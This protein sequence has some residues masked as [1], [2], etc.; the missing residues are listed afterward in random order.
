MT[1][2]GS[3]GTIS[4]TALRPRT[5]RVSPVVVGCHEGF[6]M[7]AYPVANRVGESPCWHHGQERLYWIDVRG[8][9]LLRLD[10]ATG[11][12]ER[13][14]LPDVVGSIAL[15]QSGEVWLALR[16][17]VHALDTDSGLLRLVA[18]VEDDRP[19]NR[20]NDGKVSPSGRWFVFG[21]MDDRPRKEPTGA[22]YCMSLQGELRTLWRGLVVANGIAFS[23]DGSTLYFSDSARGLVFKADWNE[24]RGCIGEP[25]IW[26]VLDEAAGRPDG[27]TVDTV[28]HYWSAGVSAGCLNVLDRSGALHRKLPVPCRAPTMPAFGGARSDVLFVTSLVRPDW[29]SAGV[30]DGA[31][32][33]LRGCGHGVPAALLGTH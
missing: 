7:L 31:L 28:G 5:D 27:A 18:S 15:C 8:Q 17:G 29:A 19:D 12:V 6:D 33:M 9:Q 30:C 10:P 1:G 3:G 32:L 21:S 25:S 2:S 14:D 16:H 20:L 24:Q 22:L 13:W 4:E 11:R 23:A 26:C